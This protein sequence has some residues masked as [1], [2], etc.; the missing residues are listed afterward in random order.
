M[1][2]PAISGDPNHDR[3]KLTAIRPPIIHPINGSSLITATPQR[4]TIIIFPIIRFHK[5]TVKTSLNKLQWLKYRSN[6]IKNI[7][8]N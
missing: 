6:S 4:T 1:N 7:T 5:K 8:I 2:P 3:S